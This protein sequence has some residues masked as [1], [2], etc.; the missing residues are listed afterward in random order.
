MSHTE[1]Y[2]RSGPFALGLKDK[3]VLEDVVYCV[4]CQ[5]C[6]AVYV[7]ETLWNLTVRLQ[8]HR[9]HVRGS[10]VQCSAVAEHA[11]AEAHQIN[12][13]GAEVLDTE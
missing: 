6:N 3:I 12:W 1:L 11:Q 7:G 9:R 13:D 4:P 2:R 5:D 8:E 10:E